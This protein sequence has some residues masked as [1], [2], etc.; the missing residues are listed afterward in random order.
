[1]KFKRIVSLSLVLVMLTGLFASGASA[2]SDIPFTDVKESQWFYSAV[3][4]V[5]QNDLML[6]VEPT[7]FAPND[8][9]SRAMFITILGR[10][11]GESG[12]ATNAFP[13]ASTDAWYSPYVGWAVKCGVIKGYDDGTLRPDV[14]L[15]R[16]EMATAMARYINAYSI[17]LPRV[18][19]A[20]EVFADN[21][22]IAAWSSDYV[23]ILRRAGITNGDE[24]GNYC[25]EQNLT[26]AEMAKVIVNL[27]EAKKNA[28]QGYEPAPT[29]DGYAVYGAIHLYWSGTAVSG[30][31][32]TD[33]S[34]SENEGYP[35]LE[36]YPDQIVASR[37]G[38]P[39]N[40]VGVCASVYEDIDLDKT[41]VVKI[42]YSYSD[43]G[44]D[45]PDAL[46]GRYVVNPS[47]ND[48]SQQYC[49]TYADEP[50]TF[51]GGEDDEGF[52]TASYDLTP[53]L[54]KHSNVID[55]IDLSHV[56]AEPFPAGYNG[57]GKFLIRYV[58]FF[59]DQKSADEFVSADQKD[60][61]MNYHLYSSAEFTELP[62]NVLS[63]SEK[64]MKDRIK[65]ILN[66]DSQITA[67][68]V[69]SSENKCWYVSSLHGNDSNNG[70]SPETAFKTVDG[71]FTWKA[72]NTIKSFKTK[73]G[74][75]VLFERGSEFYPRQYNNNSMTNMELVSGVSYG[76]YGTGAKPAFYMALDFTNKNNGRG[77]WKESGYENIWELDEIDSNP[78]WRG[79]RS[80]IGNIIFNG[81]EAYG[82]R[83]VA[84]NNGDLE[85]DEPLFGAGRVSVDYGIMS[86][87]GKNYFHSGGTSLENPAT[88]MHNNYEY[89][90][91]F[92]TGKLYLYWDKGNPGEYF[93]DIK[94]SRVGYI[95][96]GGSKNTRIDN[97]AIKYSS[98][99]GAAVGGENLTVTN[100]EFGFISGSVASIESGIE[101]FGSS[102]GTYMY[103][104]YCH[105]IGDGPL[106]LQSTSD[107][108]DKVVT[109]ENVTLKDN[110]ILACGN[111]VEIWNKCGPLDENYIGQNKIKNVHVVDNIMGYVGYGTCQ[112]Q[113]EGHRLG[114]V[115]CT[116]MG[117]M[118]NCSIENNLIIKP[119][120]EM[121]IC[122]FSSDTQKRG[123]TLIGN[124]V[125]FN[126]DQVTYTGRRDC[127]NNEYKSTLAFYGIQV[128]IPFEHRYLTYV[129][130]LGI[131]MSEKYY[132][133]TDMNEYE[134]QG[135]FYMTGYKF[136]K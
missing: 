60:Y 83:V 66:S 11:S 46:D 123:W 17:R 57:D 16:A 135:S 48:W 75:V 125:I 68:D 43:Y 136:E 70:L 55:A 76:A 33:L 28:W 27:I 117:E 102:N 52:K 112:R 4:D 108:P 84:T 111:G 100:C 45:V 62:E 41:P 26:R 128:I 35:S 129:T 24:S 30:G 13:D 20:P 1:M 38:T 58:G 21:E 9:I 40:S 72:N 10:L 109:I 114:T 34:K 93:K 73:A 107:G 65:E 132:Y 104:N 29:D 7:V 50:F 18:G 134:K 121:G 131:A 74:D 103:N 3:K 106:S 49:N 47:L 116:S 5:Y 99:W 67:A 79:G 23:E 119:A 92:H 115:I 37:H 87:D 71:L 94:C 133:Y 126:S 54:K 96:A 113:E 95:L 61:L 98:T 82:I 14:P 80:D 42:C 118:E 120:G 32:G 25:P 122:F 101:L 91:D 39:A 124:T 44:D 53:L 105:D 63:E 36:A 127:F 89:I 6:G 85:D 2:A 86:G 31:L 51:A 22:Q 88:A 59:P 97:I 81:G 110:V 64:L 15:T 12:E 130:S 8:V 56:L 78:E 90:H 77:V 19:T 69:A